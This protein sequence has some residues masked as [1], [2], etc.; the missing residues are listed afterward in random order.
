M[1]THQVNEKASQIYRFFIITGIIIV[2]FNLRPAITSIGPLI[3]VIRD[4]VGLSNW[5]VGL[6]TSLPL[7][8]FA[9]MSPVAP[10]LGNRFT[11]E[12]ALLLGLLL[13]LIGILVRSISVI[14]LLFLG[15]LFVG[16][17]IAI[18]NVLLPGV[19]KEK[20][21]TKVGLMTSIYSTAMGIFAAGASGV[22]VP[23]ASGL[24]L[25]WQLAL[26][27]WSIPA[28]LG[29]VIWAYLAKR[30]KAETTMEMQYVSTTDNRM[31]RS[32]LAWQVAAYMGF[33]S[34]LFYVTISWLPEILH[35]Y[36]VSMETAGWMLSFTQFV[37]LPASFLVPVIAEKFASQRGIVL[38]MGTFA[39]SGYGGLLIG[40]SY[41]VMVISTILIG[42]ALSGSFALALSF[43]AMRARNAKQA[44][45]LS[46]MAQAFGYI[47]AAFGPMF[48]GYLYD[49][50][51]VWTIPLFTLIIV[52]ILVVLFG[53]GAGRNR[54][55]L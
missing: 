27:V 43:L 9:V 16:L 17:G 28:V 40:S 23:L 11:N 41:I 10:R 13:L 24:N 48:I 39:V 53:L 33:Q 44:A 49:I 21:P 4:D 46:G 35:D 20:F 32:P 25:G 7:I 18:S 38:V 26:I 22:S 37:G 2:A 55:V 1:G 51:H 31:W 6:L 47:L 12:R 15:T 3:G 8:A 19:V 54:Y 45:E 42:I 52:A 50:T 34:F 29:I 5:S 14:F 30:R 36:G